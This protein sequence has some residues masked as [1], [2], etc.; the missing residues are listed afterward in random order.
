M[1]MH[2]RLHVEGVLFRVKTA[3]HIKRKCLIGPASELC[4]YL[5]YRYGVLVNNTVK[6]LIFLGEGRK[7]LYCSEIVSHSK[8]SRR[9]NA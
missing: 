3:S 4:R 8:I 7:I 6:G 5:T 1:L 2:V 9:L